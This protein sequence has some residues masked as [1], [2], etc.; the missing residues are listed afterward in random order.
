MTTRSDALTPASEIPDGFTL[1]VVHPGSFFT[2]GRGQVSFSAFE[3][4][5]RGLVE[6]LERCAG[7]VVIDGAFS[8]GIPAWFENDLRAKFAALTARG[9]TSVRAWGDDGGEDPPQW[10]TK[11]PAAEA[12]VAD[13]QEAVARMLAASLR[14]QTLVCAGAWATRDDSSGCV[15][16]VAQALRAEG[17]GD[18]HVGD[19]AL[20]E[21]DIDP[22]PW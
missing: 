14:E 20:Q 19:F 11:G 10:W 18:V 12:I 15:T 17:L 7:L 16:S 3:E 22:E 5:E 2:S 6:A 9:A 1:V 21:E 4:A 8:D 13:G